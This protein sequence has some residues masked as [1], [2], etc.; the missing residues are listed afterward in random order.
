MF[1]GPDRFK[2]VD[3]L[4]FLRTYDRAATV[5]RTAEDYRDVTYEYLVSCAARARST[6][7]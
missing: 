6:S 7:S 2:W 1:D 3:F 4:D 5:I